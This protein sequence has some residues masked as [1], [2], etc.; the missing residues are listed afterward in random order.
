M[1][2][3]DELVGLLGWKLQGEQNL[4]RFEDGFDHAAKRAQSFASKMATV[5][6]AVARV[7][8][9]AGAAAAAV[10]TKLGFDVVKQSAQFER[11]ELMFRNLTGSTK[12]AADMMNYLNKVAGTTPFNL[13][14]VVEAA[15]E[16]SAVKIDPRKQ[17]GLFT[18]L[19]DI[20]AG[21]GEGY[22]KIAKT[23]GQTLFGKFDVFQEMKGVRAGTEGGKTFWYEYFD[24]QGKMARG[25]GTIGNIEDTQKMWDRVFSHLKGGMAL[26]ASSWD[27]IIS[28][29]ED[30][31][32]RFLLA[33]GRAG[34]FEKLKGHFK[35]L[36]DYVERLDNE[37]VLDDVASKIS[38]IFGGITDAAAESIKNFRFVFQN[39]ASFRPMIY[40]L[41]T[42]L[43]VLAAAAFPV[44]SA[45]LAVGVA[46]AKVF[47]AYRRWRENREA[48]AGKRGGAFGA[49]GMDLGFVSYIENEV[50]PVM[51]KSVDNLFNTIEKKI[52]AW[53]PKFDFSFLTE[54]FTTGFGAK[55]RSIELPGAGDLLKTFAKFMNPGLWLAKLLPG[56]DELFDGI[57]DRFNKFVFN[58][59]WLEKGKELLSG[60]WNG[61]KSVMD[62]ML[63]WF[64]AKLGHMSESLRGM[65]VVS[66]TSITTPGGRVPTGRQFNP[67]DK[68]LNALP[69]EKVPEAELPLDLSDRPIG[70]EPDVQ[71]GYATPPL[72]PAQP[73]VKTNGV[74][75]SMNAPEIDYGEPPVAQF[76]NAPEIHYGEP[77]VAQFGKPP[78]MFAKF[79]PPPAWSRW[80]GN[81]GGRGAGN[82]ITNVGDVSV[83]VQVEQATDAPEQIASATLDAIVRRIQHDMPPRVTAQIG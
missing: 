6:A 52:K 49:G 28:N 45:I 34:F 65:N 36:Q 83:K 74:P 79:Q 18:Y 7:G 3:V 17:Q 66:P 43:T 68:M 22:Q 47:S 4:K 1:P 11:Y 8:L 57:I 46:T 40:G 55:I 62:P 81:A 21:L 38:A 63:S 77:P 71:P 9:V 53:H 5:G 48:E 50:T 64:D 29:L 15:Q 44:P 16:L 35:S 76:G 25:T 78:E 58:S 10:G 39:W 24:A 72:F 67:A 12:E 14:Q 41:A 27:G 51:L 82:T 32:S 33:I 13:D 31:W 80:F 26:L 75:L 60:F 70:T 20:A 19:G 54:G 56:F 30:S 23:Y 37:G 2:I 59:A 61:L 69:N 42:A 73:E